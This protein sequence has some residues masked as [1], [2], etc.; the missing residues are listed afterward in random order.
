MAEAD[1]GRR[2]DLELERHDGRHR[3]RRP[4]PPAGGYQLRVFATVGKVRGEP[5][6]PVGLTIH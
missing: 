5:S 3:R 6:Q 4:E 1:H 2:Q